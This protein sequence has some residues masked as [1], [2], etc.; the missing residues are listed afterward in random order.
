M[1]RICI[2]FL[3]LFF[4]LA[5]CYC[6]N[7]IIGKWLSADGQ[8]ITEIYQQDNKFYGKIFWLKKPNDNK[9]Y[10]YT[11]TENPDKSKRSQPLLGLIILK[12]LVFKNN[13]WQ[14]RTIWISNDKLKVRGY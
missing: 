13:Q 14:Y 4:G 10:P 3:M 8:G 5:K 2:I 11:D 12:D 1:N 6:Q 7:Q 9:G